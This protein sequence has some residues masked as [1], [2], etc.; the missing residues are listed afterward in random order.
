MSDDWDE[1]TKR[2]VFAYCGGDPRV[3][4]EVED[5]DFLSFGDEEWSLSDFRAILDKA[6]TNAR[7]VLTSYS[8][9]PSALSIKWKR[10]QTPEEVAADVQRAIDYVEAEKRR[11][12]DAYEALKRKFESAA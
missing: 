6:P 1:E 3:A 4:R 12:R 11:D 8:E 2:A 7:V 9:G 5:E 10:L